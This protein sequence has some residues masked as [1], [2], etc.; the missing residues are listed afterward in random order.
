MVVDFSMSRC[1]VRHP[2]RGSARRMASGRERSEGVRANSAPFQM[3][4]PIVTRMVRQLVFLFPVLTV[5]V[6]T[7]TADIS[8]LPADHLQMSLL[9]VRG[10]CCRANNFS[11]QNSPEAW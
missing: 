3:Q 11:L 10:N 8:C 1:E 4:I 9:L 6:A 5:K 7:L 2:D